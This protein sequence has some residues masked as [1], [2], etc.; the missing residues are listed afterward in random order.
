MKNQHQPPLFHEDLNSALSY[1]ISALGGNKKVGNDMWPSMTPDK[2]GRKI[3]DCLN[4]NHQQKF[5]PDD[6]IWLLREGRK[7]GIHSA[8]AYLNTECGYQEPKAV[9]PEDEYAALMRDFL[10]AQQHMELLVD[11]M[12]RLTP[13]AR[14][15]DRRAVERRGVMGVA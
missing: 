10:S 14:Q 5:S 6:I 2:A 7:A 13:P 12:E 15:S 11:R 4:D 3:A 9:E 1:L 8:M